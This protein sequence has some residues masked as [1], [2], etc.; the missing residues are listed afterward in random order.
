MDIP[1]NEKADEM[2]KEAAGSNG[3][4]HENPFQYKPLKSMRNN[5]I[6]QTSKNEWNSILKKELKSSHL[7][8]ITNKVQTKP[9][10]V[11]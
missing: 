2:A 3:S 6:K 7:H 4:T 5:T 9:S 1:G 10:S 11:L 8:R